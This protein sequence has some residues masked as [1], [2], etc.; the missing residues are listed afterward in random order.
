MLKISGASQPSQPPIVSICHR[1]LPLLKALAVSG[2]HIACDQLI[3]F[4]LPRL[5]PSAQSHSDV[6]QVA[7]KCNSIGM[8][9]QFQSDTTMSVIYN[10]QYAGA[11]H[12]CFWTHLCYNFCVTCFPAKLST[13]IPPSHIL[14]AL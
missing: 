3:H 4:W 12:A 7:L 10:L 9:N 8:A 2:F 5:F 11:E 1:Q 14:R 13:S 6:V